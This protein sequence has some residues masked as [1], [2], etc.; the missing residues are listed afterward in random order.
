MVHGTPYDGKAAFGQPRERAGLLVGMTVG[1]VVL[2]AMVGAVGYGLWRERPK[3]KGMECVEN[4]RQ[5][6][7]T[8][9]TGPV[10]APENAVTVMHELDAV[11][12]FE[13]DAEREVG[14]LGTTCEEGE[15]ES[16]SS[17]SVGCA[18]DSVDR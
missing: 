4:M 18:D 1:V 12:Y 3:G 5:V 13:I 11:E 8:V 10:E 16:R 6:E 9:E 14:E 17:S 2:V 7:R 15:M